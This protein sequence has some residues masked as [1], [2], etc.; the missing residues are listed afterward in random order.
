MYA[1]HRTP[2]TANRIG[3][4]VVCAL[5]AGLFGGATPPKAASAVT[6]SVTE[7]PQRVT[8]PKFPGQ[9]PAPPPAI[10][11]EDV[12]RVVGADTKTSRSPLPERDVP[13]QPNDEI[14]RPLDAPLPEPQNLP[15]VLPKRDNEPIVSLPGDP[16][17]DKLQVVLRID[18]PR[19]RN[20]DVVT[21]V[22]FSA[23]QD[24]VTT[25]DGVRTV[26][27]LPDG[28]V[29][30]DGTSKLAVY[31]RDRRTLTWESLRLER[32]RSEL[33]TLALKLD[34][35]QVP[36]TL[37]LTQTVEALALKR[38]K[39]VPL[40]LW[41]GSDETRQSLRPS[42]G[43]QL[44]VSDR[45]TIDFAPKVIETDAAD[46]VV[47]GTVY[48][49][50]AVSDPKAAPHVI[51]SVGPDMTFG[52]PVTATI[53]LNGLLPEALAR[54]IAEGKTDPTF[55]GLTLQY[56][57]SETV[58][59]TVK[60]PEGE[61]ER[62]TTLTRFEDV[63]SIFDPKTG[64][65]QAQLKHFSTY[66]VGLNQP[67]DPKP[68]QFQANAPGVSLYRGSSNYSYPIYTPPLQDGLQPRIVLNYSSATADSRSGGSWN[69]LPPD[70]AFTVGRGW[71]MDVPKITRLVKRGW[72]LN[73][74]WYVFVTDYRNLFTLELNGQTHTLV[75]KDP[76]AAAGEYVPETYVPIR[77][78]RCNARAAT[79][80]YAAEC[81]QYTPATATPPNLTGEYWQVRT[82]DGTL[83]LFGITGE[84]ANIVEQRNFDDVPYSKA[85]TVT[86]NT[87]YAGEY[88]GGIVRSWFLHGVY[89][90]PRDQ[91][92]SGS[93]YYAATRWTAAYQYET[94]DNAIENPACSG[95]P[96]CATKPDP[97]TRPTLIQYG[98][99]IRTDQSDQPDRFKVVFTY[100]SYWKPRLDAV[101]VR[102]GGTDLRRY[103]L[104]YETYSQ[105]MVDVNNVVNITE[106]YPDSAASGGW[107]NFPIASSFIYT[108]S[109]FGGDNAGKRLLR[110]VSN[111][112]GGAWTFDYGANTINNGHHVL[113]MTVNSGVGTNA[114]Q[115]HTYVYEGPCYDTT[116]VV[117][118][119]F[120]PGR[121][122]K[123]GDDGATDALMGYNYTTERVRDAANTTWSC[124]K[125][126]FHN[127]E[128]PD[129]YKRL[130]REY[131]TRFYD[132][133]NGGASTDTFTQWHY[134][135][136][137]QVTRERRKIQWLGSGY[138]P[139]GTYDTLFGYDAA[140]RATQMTYP[141]GDAISTAFAVDGRAI[142]LT[143]SYAGPIVTN[144][145]YTVQ[146]QLAAR[147]G[148]G[149]NV[150]T[151]FSYHPTNFRL[152]GIQVGS[153]WTRNYTYDS[154]GNVSTA[155]DAGESLSYT[156]DALARLRGVSG[157]YTETYS[158]DPVGNLI[159][160]G[161]QV[162]LHY[163]GAGQA[164]PHAPTSFIPPASGT[165]QTFYYDANGNMT[166]RDLNASGPGAN[167][168]A[169]YQGYTPD[170]KLFMAN[171]Y[172]W[173][174]GAGQWSYTGVSA[175]FYYDADGQRVR[176]DDVNGITAYAGAHFEL[177][178]TTYA[179]RATYSFNG[180]VVAVRNGFTTSW[181]HAD[182][183]G[184]ASLATDVTGA[185]ISGSETR[186]TPWGEVRTG[187]TL[188]TDRGFTS[189]RR[190]ATIGL[191]DYVA[192]FYDPYIGKF[193]SPDSIVP[194]AGNPQSF[195]R[196]SYGFN[197]PLAFVDP[198]G[199]DPWWNNDVMPVVDVLDYGVYI[200]FD[201]YSQSMWTVEGLDRA[202]N[203]IAELADDLTF[204]CGSVCVG[205]QADEVSRMLS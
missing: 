136:R 141:D 205:M 38:A 91:V 203:E 202:S 56:L 165:Y 61:R 115:V 166:W 52:A 153:T 18:Q 154:V 188:P 101:T 83:Y 17:D 105:N 86:T 80:P 27:A 29:Y 131:Q 63:P 79:T 196:F 190:E 55:A 118:Y 68:W 117:N 8:T 147:T 133:N 2:H 69:A 22:L 75:P 198:S 6:E 24:D 109:A 155:S 11:R 3:I 58:T 50:S 88:D 156:Y 159:D 57:R 121:G 148:S 92:G 93:Y 95:Q 177:N 127:K 33:D 59:Q 103:T 129:A 66:Q 31:D 144:A 145:S 82:P 128:A 113:T 13:V 53:D 14:T 107:R 138:N 172:A 124:V 94:Y 130:G 42:E 204:A 81:A 184:S 110:Q 12:A 186:Y 96:E 162:Q 34:V 108:N 174:A 99:H 112:Y 67:A 60:T 19:R 185:L 200:Q 98:Y 39:T 149:G 102:W 183:L 104:G 1:A 120:K 49:S 163:P 157:T 122:V 62:V 23:V 65:L 46:I 15:F 189:Q 199:H 134:D 171:Q 116:G 21:A 182:H 4:V 161:S 97:V 132:Y 137:G 164:R 193:I 43:G 167:P 47:T 192:R 201:N 76:S 85:L 181:I 9:P 37:V 90:L 150:T 135:E 54:A 111:G 36:T 40:T 114:V 191:S 45:I 146:G 173:D 89:S 158:Y 51:F 30:V 140:G 70:S 73:G 123:A 142:S 143:S 77:V 176:K 180:Q 126:R 84:S 64:L 35:T 125:H 28:V 71:S 119:C 74:S 187:G 139:D 44:R 168:F 169:Y 195:N 26:V 197:N 7:L 106:S 152:Q 48:A 5:V 16:T 25:L 87:M 179:Q 194:G 20:G 175:Y 100:N 170:N 151:S 41:V 72:Q 178:V 32:G 160:K 78:L 10:K